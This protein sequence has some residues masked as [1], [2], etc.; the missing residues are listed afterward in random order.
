MSI[1]RL[2]KYQLH[3]Q[4]KRIF[5]RV[6]VF[7][8]NFLAG[9]MFLLVEFQCIPI[10]SLLPFAKWLIAWLWS[11]RNQSFPAWFIPL[12]F[13]FM[14]ILTAMISSCN[15]WAESFSSIITL[16]HILP[17]LVK[18][19]LGSTE[20]PCN[21]RSKATP[22]MILYEAHHLTRPQQEISSLQGRANQMWLEF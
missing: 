15:T 19:G 22:V 18:G 8:L 14:Q 5:Q 21:L 12:K 1:I 6:K 16:K 2:W 11:S 7:L 4:K 13:S 20:H 17:V 3:H 9:N 10:P